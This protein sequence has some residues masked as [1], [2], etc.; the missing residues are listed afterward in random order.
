MQRIEIPRTPKWL[1]AIK[2]VVLV[3][4]LY[5]LTQD[6]LELALKKSG[7][8]LVLFL[9]QYVLFA[10]IPWISILYQDFFQPRYFVSW[11]DQQINWQVPGMKSITTL[12]RSTVSDIN[13]KPFVLKVT[14]TTG[15]HD[16]DISPFKDK[17][18][19][20]IKAGLMGLQ[21]QLA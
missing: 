6:G 11:D 20:Q 4:L 5:S 16:I 3:V 1:A 12:N 19:E 2:S 8:E 15:Q 9:S 21:P 7:T 17:A 10:M 13:Y 14:T 18:A